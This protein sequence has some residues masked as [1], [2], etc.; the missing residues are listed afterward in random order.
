M[1]KGFLSQHAGNIMEF[2]ASPSLM[3]ELSPLLTLSPEEAL[4]LSQATGGDFIEM[5]RLAEFR[6][7]L[8]QLS[9]L[10]PDVA[11][12]LSLN[13]DGIEVGVEKS[14]AGKLYPSI[15]RGTIVEFEFARGSVVFKGLLTYAGEKN[16]GEGSYMAFAF[17]A[18]QH[19]PAI[20][21]LLR[22]DIQSIKVVPGQQVEKTFGLNAFKLSEGKLSMDRGILGMDGSVRFSDGMVL[23]LDNPSVMLVPNE[24][25][26]ETGEL[27]KRALTLIITQMDLAQMSLADPSLLNVVYPSGETSTIIHTGRDLQVH[28]SHIRQGHSLGVQAVETKVVWTGVIEQK[29]FYAVRL[30]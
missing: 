7:A 2:L 5:L 1:N 4:Q 9:K 14:L 22:E 18:E 30:K 10:G 23:R 27:N 8:N 3:S 17:K 29:E 15:Q 16:V 24:N 20:F 13:A 25:P 26:F 11:R 6:A 12:I 21:E 28:Y 19:V